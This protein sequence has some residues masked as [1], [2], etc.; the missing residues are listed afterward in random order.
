MW[1]K[2]CLRVYFESPWN[3][4]VVNKHAYW[5]EL[6]WSGLIDKLAMIQIGCHSVFTA[7]HYMQRDHLSDRQAVCL[8]VCPSITH[9]NCDKTTAPSEK[10]SIMTNRKSPTS[11]PMSLRWTAYIAPNPQ[12]GP[13]KPI[14]S[15]HIPYKN[16]AF[17]E[18]S[19]L[20]SFFVWKLSAAK[21]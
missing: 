2:F 15:L 8:S 19:L 14:F 7:L 4:A 18:E 16:W 11:F 1:S 5:W 21:L 6:C 10:S 12:R 20:Q 9:M 3:M 13:Q 17:R